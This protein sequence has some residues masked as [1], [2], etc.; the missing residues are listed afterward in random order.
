MPFDNM[1]GAKEKFG[2]EDI[3]E[4]KQFVATVAKRER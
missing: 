4:Y 2:L 1:E 3:E